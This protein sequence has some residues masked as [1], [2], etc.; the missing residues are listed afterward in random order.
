MLVCESILWYVACPLIGASA[1]LPAFLPFLPFSRPFHRFSPTAM[2]SVSALVSSLPD[3]LLAVKCMNVSL[4]VPLSFGT[5][6]PWRWTFPVISHWDIW[7][8]HTHT[9]IEWEEISLE[10]RF[11]LAP[12]EWP[13]N[14][15][16]KNLTCRR[17]TF[18]TVQV[19]FSI[20]FLCY[21]LFSVVFFRLSKVFFPR[22]ITATLWEYI[23]P[24]L[25]WK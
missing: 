12:G 7:Q 1:S 21:F 16:K 6:F 18:P 15:V 10:N 17:M 4:C 13:K 3:P 19:F 11:K 14:N 25:L 8:T 20:L 23:N 22:S 9:H 2:L 24:K 5:W